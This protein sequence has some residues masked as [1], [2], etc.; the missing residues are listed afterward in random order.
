VK[1]REMQ[2]EHLECQLTPVIL[3]AWRTEIGGPPFKTI[4]GAI[5]SETLLKKESDVVVIF[6]IPTTE[7]I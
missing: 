4:M 5:V 7:E 1:K 3:T 6:L 2:E